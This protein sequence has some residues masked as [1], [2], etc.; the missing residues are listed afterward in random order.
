MVGRTLFL[1][2][3]MPQESKRR[4]LE[5][6]KSDSKMTS[7]HIVGQEFEDDD[8]VTI[9][10]SELFHFDSRNWNTIKLCSCRGRLDMVLEIVMST[11]VRRL[12]LASEEQQRILPAL[13]QGLESNERLLTLGLHDIQFSK[14]N[15]LLLCRGLVQSGNVMEV[16]FNKSTFSDFAHVP[17]A[18]GL[19]MWASVQHLSFQDCRLTDEQCAEII[20]SLAG[21]KSL[22]ELSL[23]GN[24]CKSLGMK[25]LGRILPNSSLLVLDLSSQKLKPGETLDLVEFSQALAKSR[26]SCLQLSD[27]RINDFNMAFLARSLCENR[28]LQVLHL[29]W[30]HLS[31]HTIEMIA[32][33]ISPNSTLSKLILYDCE[34]CD[35]GITAF[36]RHMSR[37]GGLKQLDLGG[38]QNLGVQGINNFLL[39][40]S[41]NMELDEVHL[42]ASEQTK[43]IQFFCDV[44]RAGRRIFRS[45]DTASAGLWPLI[46]ERAQE[47]ELP[48]VSDPWLATEISED[49]IFGAVCCKGEQESELENERRRAST[50]FY[51]LRNGPLLEIG[52]T[53]SQHTARVHLIQ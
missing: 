47:M 7:I 15:L 21:H 22:M 24:E 36:S 39:G 44:N 38:K 12:I 27:N 29:A 46:L 31:I 17:L 32:E 26:I 23:D 8:I 1:T 4:R 53:R 40:L 34:I 11:K 16:S 13:I 28:S 51:L 43:T 49:S 19:R 45:Q 10:L 33:G 41:T 52:K 50:L 9:M 42:P 2:G 20:S 48:C 25:A 14:D 30:C 37:M 35:A 5:Q 6:A 18:I 3:G